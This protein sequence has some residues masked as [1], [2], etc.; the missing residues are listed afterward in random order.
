M[1]KFSIREIKGLI[2]II[3][4]ISIKSEESIESVVGNSDSIINKVNNEI[5]VYKRKIILQN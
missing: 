1:N 2:I 5:I 4:I 3:K